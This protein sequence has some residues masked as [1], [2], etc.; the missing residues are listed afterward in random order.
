MMKTFAVDDHTY[1]EYYC[2]TSQYYVRLKY[3]QTLLLRVPVNG[4]LTL[5]IFCFNFDNFSLTRALGTR[6]KMLKQYTRRTLH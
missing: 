6:K 1:N 5:N 4:L 3:L 2:L